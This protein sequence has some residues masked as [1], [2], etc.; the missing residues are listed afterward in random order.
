MK[1][2]PLRARDGSVR[3]Y[4]I[5][6]D[7]DFDWL[8]QWRWFLDRGRKGYAMR[9]ERIRPG[10]QRPI[11]MHRFILGLE[12]G[13]PRQGDHRNSNSLDNRRVN[14]RIVPPGANAQNRV[15]NHN[16][17]SRYRGVYWSPAAGKWY[18]CARLNKKL[19]HLGVYDDEH[20]A[21]RVAAAFRAKH[22]PFANE[23]RVAA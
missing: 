19:H 1:K 7:A 5:V 13:D 2:I 10:L 11:A 20:E 23:A 12:R 3:A 21:G 6:D 4:A 9:Q 18:A 17:T 8:N 15:S 22:M 14:L 16:S